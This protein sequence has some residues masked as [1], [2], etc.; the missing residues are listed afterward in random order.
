MRLRVQS[1]AFVA[2]SLM[3]ASCSDTATLSPVQTERPSLSVAAALPAV[4][5]SE[6]HY[7][8]TGADVGEAVEI[9]G[10]AGTD[11]SG[12]KLVLYNGNSTIRAPFSTITLT[13]TIPAT[14]GTRGVVVINTVG[15]MNGGSS[16]TGTTDPDGFAL[17]DAG[18]SVVEFL[19]YEGSFV[20]ASGPAAGLSSTDVGVRELGTESASPVTSLQ[21]NGAGVWSGPVSN[22]FG[23][24]NDNDEPPPVVS[25]GVEPAA[26]TIVVGGAQAF[27]ATAYDA[28]NQPIPSTAFTWSSTATG[29]ATVSTSGVATG[30]APGDAEIIAAAANGKAD[31]AAL[32]VD[33]LPPAGPVF[34]SE[35]HYD[36]SGTDSGEGIEVEGPAGTD[37]TGWS[38]VLYNGN[39]GAS[40]S[41]RALSGSIPAL[42]SGRG[43]VFLS[44]PQDGI[45]NGSPDGFA[46]INAAG[47]V[48]EFLSYEGTFTAT[49][50]PANG[51]G[52]T[53]IGVSESSSPV[54]HSLKRYN[55]GN[56]YAPSA[57]SF[58]ACNGDVPPPP[59]N[60]IL[61]T[62]RT[63][64]DPALP[65]GFQD[66]L[67]ATLRDGN[68]VAIP[69]T[70]TWSSDTPLLAS[71]D[72][73][74]VM[75]A[76]GEGT[77]VI[78][79][80]AGD[81]NATTATLSLPTHVAIASTTAQYAGNA[82]FGEPADGD[83]SDD[84]IV[85]HTQYTAS[86]NKNRGTPNWVSYDLEASHFGAEDRCDCFTYDP[87]LP[88]NFTHYTT[89]DYTG[90]GTFHGY[91]IDRGHLARSFDRT[92]ASL[93]NAFTFY[94]T[95]I[96]PQAADLNQGP[97]AVLESYL[98]DQARF[99]NK[100]VY[101]IAGAAGSKGTVKDEGKIVIPASTWKVAVIMPRDQGLADIHTYQDLEVLAV[102]M[103]NDPG[104]RNVNWETYKTTVDA[105]E[106]LSGYDLLA[107]L[108]DDI[109]IAVESNTKPPVAAVDGPYSSLEGGNVAM[110]AAGSSDPDGQALSYAWDFDDGG[111][112]TGVTTAHTYAQDGSY[113]VRLIVTDVLGLA[114]TITTTA[115][116]AN[117]APAIG[118][119]AGA[120][121][122]PGE[123]YSAAGAFT[124]PGA[125]TWS[126]T[127]DYGDGSGVGPLTLAG[128]SFSLSHGYNT[129]GTFTVSVRI[130]DDDIS[131]L[132]TQTVVV[133]TPGQGV[134]NAIGLV[135]QLLARGQLA[136]GN[137]NSLKVKLEAALQQLG[138]GNATPA[139]EQLK[140]VLY[141]LDALVG[142]GQLPAVEAGPLRVLVGRVINSLL[143]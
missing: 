128:M 132:R 88:A 129:A 136:A 20:A 35:I 79:A 78:R 59:A 21:R 53:D 56:W 117:V 99:Q 116:V 119:F 127:V 12:W 41:T 54:G 113:A 44:Y 16:S 65:V 104:V 123:T 8:N 68:G 28:A 97:W 72:Q 48:V 81:A 94:F 40:Y 112:A 37:L 17:V 47:Q 30:V 96:V 67:F 85:R 73:N 63:A 83:A 109:E 133:L 143:L 92:S 122:L 33:P 114:D 89:A 26:A 93:D 108:R 90:A 100:E 80:T 10:P 43:V 52:S 39:G 19:S 130:S 101:I 6:F 4:R 103:P 25:V 15:L 42:C 57:N 140:S 142:S 131:S 29:I 105:V 23:A 111:S 60:T 110:S 64:S 31:T 106:A 137:A 46:L 71:I 2:L 70:F 14:C 98:G 102:N 27:T 139:V 107:L 86:F 61:F 13:Q 18:G 9:S 84:F 69:T 49:S 91:G 50:G 5:T 45:Q 34:F 38:V 24:C 58:G 7:D 3:L 121:L 135:D 87:A 95:N 124:D 118:A 82:E 32:H 36:N 120:T 76:L 77:A 55:D 75:T 138:T 115:S 62:G 11:L 22:T 1:A 125:D 51:M 126:A 134:Q 74:G 141:E 66:Q